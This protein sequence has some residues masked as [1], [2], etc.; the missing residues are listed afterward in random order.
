LKK[1]IPVNYIDN[2]FKGGLMANY[3]TG[4]L[5]NIQYVNDSL[6]PG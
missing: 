6:I 4:N 1:L 5:Y 3:Y 2:M